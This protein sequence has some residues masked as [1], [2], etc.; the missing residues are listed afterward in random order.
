MVDASGL[1][2]GSL[3]DLPDVAAGLRRSFPGAVSADVDAVLKTLP[4]RFPWRK[5]G[6]GEYK[7]VMGDAKLSQSFD[8]CQVEG[9]TLCL[10]HR[11]YLTKPDEVAGGL[12]ET[13]RSILGCI[14][15]RHHDGYVR[16]DALD[17]ILAGRAAWVPPFVLA[18]VGE[19]VLE[20]AQLIQR[21]SAD[22]DVEA[23]ARFGAENRVFLEVLRQRIISYWQCYDRGDIPEFENAPA[24]QTFS[25]LGLWGKRDGRRLLRRRPVG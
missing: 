20:I 15:T 18:L 19:Y 8:R 2:A 7:L 14:Y 13:Q 11:V 5:I 6:E 4:M 9:E 24:F 1:P 25:R 23:Y 10:P 12:T 3:F 17:S 22:L 16:Q 21:R